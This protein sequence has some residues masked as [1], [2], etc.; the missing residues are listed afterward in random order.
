MPPSPFFLLALVLLLHGCGTH[1]P[2]PPKKVDPF[3]G[4]IS[5]ADVPADWDIK[6]GTPT[7]RLDPNRIAD[8]VPRRDVVTKAGNKNPY[9]VLGQTYYIMPDARGYKNRGMGSW[10]GTKFHGRKT[11]NGED[12]DVY[13]MTAAH[14]T[15]PIPCYVR[16][17][18]LENG[19]KA[20]VRV[21]DRGPFLHNRI[22]DLSYAAATKLGYAEKG[23]A[24]L[25]VEYIDTN[26]INTAFAQSAP[27]VARAAS[28]AKIVAAPGKPAEPYQA[29]QSPRQYLQ[30]GAYGNY[31]A[32]KQLAD[33]LQKQISRP[34]FVNADKPK[35]YRVH[36][37]PISAH[38]VE[39]VRSQLAAA[40]FPNAHFVRD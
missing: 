31:D 1:A 4:G 30:V 39:Q 32:A 3:K 19:R 23:T 14:K 27:A 13:A 2:K 37:G 40:N 21:N 16:V 15:L 25:E 17:T 22:I 5:A 28:P 35:L 20:V 24:Y 12:Y 8:A 34:V 9:V 38:E 33:R 18:N 7:L 29:L 6:D 26:N 10:Y 11:S 36:V